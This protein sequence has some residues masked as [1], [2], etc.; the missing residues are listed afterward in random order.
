MVQNPRCESSPLYLSKQP[1]S[2]E[3]NVPIDDQ[4][5]AADSQLLEKPHDLAKDDESKLPTSANPDY[6]FIA[7]G[8]EHLH[9]LK[10]L[11]KTV[12]P[13]LT[14]ADLEEY[15]DFVEELALFEDDIEI[16]PEP[17]DFNL[18]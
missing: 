13:N 17:N 9:L 11:Q 15:E 5:S 3:E 1:V 14:V 8:D 10:E 4:E 12:D 7:A 2:T 6:V 18:F 16:E